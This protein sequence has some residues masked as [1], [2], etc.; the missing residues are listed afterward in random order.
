MSSAATPLFVLPGTLNAR[1]EAIGRHVVSALAAALSGQPDIGPQMA[2]G[3]AQLA[4]AEAP[5][6]KAATG[7]LFLLFLAGSAL[8]LRS[9]RTQQCQRLS[10]PVFTKGTV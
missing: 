9:L 5:E 10:N 3:D 2:D 7:V 1:A 4:S 6:L 8:Q